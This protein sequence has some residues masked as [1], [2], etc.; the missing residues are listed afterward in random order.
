MTPPSWRTRLVTKLSRSSH[1][2]R[3]LVVVLS[4]ALLSGGAGVVAWTLKGDDALTPQRPRTTGVG[5][6]MDKAAKFSLGL[7]HLEHPGKDITVIKVEALTSPNIEYLGAFTTWPRD[8]PGNQ[9]S[10]VDGFPPR[11]VKAP[12]HPLGEVIPA[13]ETAVILPGY[14]ETPPPVSVVAGFRLASGDIGAVNGIRV[15]Y[16]VGTTTMS[17]T[18]RY[19]VIACRPACNKRADF[20]E[21]DFSERTLRRFDL[22]PDSI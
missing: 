8:M 10:G 7:M 1:R 13:A 12:R 18:F 22:L 5:I 17:E 20:D 15:T 4:L 9:F 19:A 14:S 6:S 21:N 16:K 2:A 3:I 11:Y